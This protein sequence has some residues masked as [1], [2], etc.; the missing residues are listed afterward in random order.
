MERNEDCIELFCSVQQHF[1][2]K[3]T[4]LLSWT[5]QR[6]K[7]WL[8]FQYGPTLA[9]FV[10]FFSVKLFTAMIYRLGIIQ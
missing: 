4:K 8:S 2:I 7:S 6:T 5:Y 1:Y 3:T 10:L 9:F